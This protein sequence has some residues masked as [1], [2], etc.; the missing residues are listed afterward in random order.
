MKIIHNKGEQC[1][2][3]HAGDGNVIGKI[4]YEIRDAHTLA[5]IRTEVEKE[6][7]GQGYAGRL[8]QALVQY[9]RRHWFRIIPVCSYVIA[10]FK[11]HPEEYADVAAPENSGV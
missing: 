11:R 3:L 2:E 5:A 10:A 6:Y 1:F 9:A 7:E 4:V 8:L